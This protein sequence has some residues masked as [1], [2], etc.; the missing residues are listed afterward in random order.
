[1]LREEFPWP[2]TLARRDVLKWSIPICIGLFYFV[3]LI[4]VVIPEWLLA[5]VHF[6]RQSSVIDHSQG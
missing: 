2:S 6:S 5:M 1:M 4:C 3:R